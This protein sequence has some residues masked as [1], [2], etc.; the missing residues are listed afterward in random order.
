MQTGTVTTADASVAI[1]TKL[2]DA[3]NDYLPSK[4]V[5][6]HQNCFWILKM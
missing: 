6:N 2:T 3:P 5:M 1:T 4:L